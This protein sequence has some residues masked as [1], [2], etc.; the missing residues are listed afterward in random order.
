MAPPIQIQGRVILVVTTSLSHLTRRVPCGEHE[1]CFCYVQ[2]DGSHL[3]DTKC[4]CRGLG[5]QFSF[6]R[7]CPI[8]LHREAAAVQA[9]EEQ[10]AA[11]FS[12]KCNFGKNDSIVQNTAA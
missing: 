3:P 6:S 9:S 5:A 7:V 10:E 12:S 2:C 8:D 11:Y 1:S 4:T